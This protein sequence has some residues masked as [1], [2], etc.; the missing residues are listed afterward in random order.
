MPKYE[1]LGIQIINLYDTHL[2]FTD[3]ITFSVSSIKALVPLRDYLMKI[4]NN[5]KVNKLLLLTFQSGDTDDVIT[6]IP[7]IYM[8]DDGRV[9]LELVANGYLIQFEYDINSPDEI[10]YYA[11]PISTEE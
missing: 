10:A 2:T 3:G 1:P 11:S 9:N 5:Q 8:T 4:G 7:T 6:T